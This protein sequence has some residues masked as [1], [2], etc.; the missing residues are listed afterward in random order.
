M[1]R[2]ARRYAVCAAAKAITLAAV[3]KRWPPNVMRVLF[4]RKRERR[5]CRHE[6]ESRHPA[7]RSCSSQSRVTRCTRL[8][9]PPQG[10]SRFSLCAKTTPPGQ[11]AHFSFHKSPALLMASPA[12][13]GLRCLDRE[14]ALFGRQ[15]MP[16]SPVR[17]AAAAPIGYSKRC[18]VPSSKT[19][20]RGALRGVT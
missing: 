14:P 11:G 9:A 15:T 12:T 5:S 7:P 8:L 1:V 6:Q 18:S 19:P 13:P 10:R 20:R 3:I 2:R 17:S 16:S 4:R